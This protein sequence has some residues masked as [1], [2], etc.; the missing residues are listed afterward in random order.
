MSRH[1]SGQQFSITHGDHRATVVEVGGG[2]REYSV[3]DRRVLDPYPLDAM[4]D[5]AHGA[6]LIPWPNR[7]ADGQYRF[8]GTDHQLPLTEPD[9]ANAI[10]GLLRWRT[11]NAVESSTS[12][13]VMM[14]SLHP[15]KGYPFH[16]D[17]SV[18]YELDGVGLTVETTA[19][20][21]GT[22]TLPYA[23]GQ[24][25]YLSPGTGVIDDCLLELGAAT[26]ILTDNE[27]QLPTGTGHVAGT[28]FDFNR[29]RRIGE[30]HLDLPFTDL[31]RDSDGRAHVRL[32]GVDGGCVDLW[33]DEHYPIVELYSGDTLAADRQRLGLGAEPMTCPPNG[34]RTGD[35][36]LR[37][38]PGQSITTRW[39]VSLV[40]RGEPG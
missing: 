24:H 30:L 7:L 36:L 23:C 16:L 40:A 15:M 33:V 17:V 14:T 5:G 9:K 21:V 3:G 8:D 34:F 19:R 32:T 20:N 12:R 11:W 28:P 2:I 6:V 38:E 25:P 13:V 18:A 39:G 26:R 31:V 1:P 4:C 37:I 29:P 35:G 22:A 10:H 27:R